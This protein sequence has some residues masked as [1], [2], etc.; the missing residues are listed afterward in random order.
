MTKKFSTF[1]VG[2]VATVGVSTTALGEEPYKGKTLRFIVAFSP[3]GGFDLYTRAIAR[4]ISKHLP[5]HP[6]TVVQ[7]MTGAAGLISANYIYKKGPRSADTTFLDRDG[8][9]L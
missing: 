6:T 2:L 4:H 8:T 9:G 1:L 3:G 5:G 7:N